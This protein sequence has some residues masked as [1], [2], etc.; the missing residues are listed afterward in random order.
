MALDGDTGKL[1]WHFQFTPHDSHDWDST[2]VPVLFDAEIRGQRRKLVA[3]A[4][5]NAFYYVLDRTSGEFIAGRAYAKQTWAKGLDDRGRPLVLPNTEPSAEGTLVFPNLNGATVWFSP[6]YSP[7]TG[8]FYVAVRE[9]GA[10]YYKREAEFK[11][12]TFFA[13]GGDN[14]IPNGE[15]S[16]ALRALDAT[17]GHLQWE[18]PAYSAPWAGVLSTGGG[19]V[20]SGTPRRKFLCSCR[21]AP[22]S[23]SGIFRPAE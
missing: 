12:G 1:S 8:M 11:P 13:G 16:G 20:F 10:I 4:N 3:V 22:A 21:R 17:T 2:H 5:R 7:K 15:R 6:S 19:L 9:I 18:F 23:P 14:D